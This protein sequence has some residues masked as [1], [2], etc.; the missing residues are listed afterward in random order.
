MDGADIDTVALGIERADEPR[1][2]Q[3]AWLE[4]L[5]PSAALRLSPQHA[6]LAV[7]VDDADRHDL[8]RLG[9]D[10]RDALTPRDRDAAAG[11]QREAEGERRNTRGSTL[12][13]IQ[14]RAAPV[15]TARSRDLSLLLLLTP[16]T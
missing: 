12:D 16:P 10:G 5:L 13:F 9:A 2:A 6:G 1:L 3:Q 11:Q 14:V 7:R 15:V 4:R 8:V